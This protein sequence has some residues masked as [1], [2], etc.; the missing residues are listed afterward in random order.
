MSILLW[1]WIIRNYISLYKTL[2]AYLFVDEHELLLPIIPYETLL[3]LF[4]EIALS[5]SNKWTD[6]LN[7]LGHKTFK[8]KHSVT[9][10]N[11]YD[12][13]IELQRQIQ[14]RGSPQNLTKSNAINLQNKQKPTVYSWLGTGIFRRKLW[15]KTSYVAS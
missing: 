14:K 7:S 6:I 4:P 3:K 5:L 8:S 11:K 2:Q 13:N 15:V 9:V 10:S 1:S 12:T